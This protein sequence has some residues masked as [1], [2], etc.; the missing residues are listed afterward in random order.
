[1]SD[2]RYT[3][4]IGFI[5]TKAPLETS[6]VRKLLEMAIES[7]KKNNK[8]GFFLISDGVFLI[9]NN[10]KNETSSL[11]KD[12]SAK[13]VEIIVSKDHLES[14]GISSSDM[15]CKVSISEK[16]YDDLVDFAMEKYER[17]V[18]I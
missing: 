3:G 5:F 14:A 1:M 2:K 11:F 6:V 16:P 8:I 9:K 17:V 12:I 18:T 7:L 15:C 10:Q 4:D 13:T